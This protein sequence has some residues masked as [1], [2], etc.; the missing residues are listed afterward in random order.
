MSLRIVVNVDTD[1]ADLE[2]LYLAKEVLK[3]VMKGFDEDGIE[4][5]TYLAS[6]FSDV[7]AEIDRKN[8][9]E[10]ERQLKNEEAKRNTY[11]SREEKAKVA[12]ARIADLKKKLGRE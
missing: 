3:M 11:M 4:I 8:R 10:L 7:I 9:S 6:K 5:P 1:T 12:D 2:E